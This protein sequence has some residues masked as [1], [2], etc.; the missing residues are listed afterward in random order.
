MLRTSRRFSF[1]ATRSTSAAIAGVLLVGCTEVKEQPKS[2]GPADVGGTMVVATPAEP[3][4]ILPGLY[5]TSIERQVT[6]LLFDRLAEIGDGLNSIG[7][8]GFKPQL[9]TRWEWSPDSLSIVFHLDPRARWHDGQ[10][11]RAT[12]VRYSVNLIKDPAFGSPM[13][14]STTNVDSVSVRDSLTAVAHFKRHT[15]E[16][17]FDLVYQVSI[18]PE[19]ILGNTP[20][21]QLKTAEV[22][23]RGIG[24]GRFRLG[25]W[26][27][28][29]SLELVADTLNYRGRPKLDRIVYSLSLDFN[30]AVARLFTG[31]A[32]FFEQLRPENMAKLATDTALRALPYPSLQHTFLALNTIDPAHPGQPNPIFADRAVRRALTMAVDRAGMLR[33][34]F[35]V[36]AH[37]SYGPFPRFLGVA[38][39][40]LPQLPYDT[41]KARALLDSAGWTP[42]PDGVRSKNGQRLE[43]GITTTV[44]SASRK[45]YSVL[46]QEAFKRVGAV[47]TVDAVDFAGAAAKLQGRS[48]QTV[49]VT[50]APDPNVSGVRQAWSSAALGKDGLNYPSYVNPTVDALLD[51]A[52]LAFDPA[53]AR[54]YSR[55]AFE[56]IIEDAPGIWLYEA[57]T[58]AGIHKRI[59]TTGLRADEYWAGMADWWIPAS[60]RTARDR[61]GLR[62]AA[63][64]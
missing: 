57:P 31:D 15:P 46:L 19:H 26:E 63:T 40:T 38:D 7:D 51:S 3:G 37:P 54:A 49:L 45:Q 27:Q 24:S 58:V 50:F 61:I 34:V 18:V 55:R 2:A 59:H 29:K 53:R 12:D 62:P 14:S 43:F 13:A 8:K 4:S 11:V 20:P 32:D 28:G 1:R 56:I 64:P 17:F 10:P 36:M 22:A 48:F 9:A 25:K 35:G 42:G 5:S 41:V 52:T 33:N 6:D 60:E 30:S 16:Q 47:A 23:R 39:T 21:A 44:S